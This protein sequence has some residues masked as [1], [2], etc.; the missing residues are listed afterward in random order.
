MFFIEY[1]ETSWYFLLQI[2]VSLDMF[3][4]LQF[5]KYKTHAERFIYEHLL[6]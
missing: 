6:G 5:I 4:F 2:L 1:I 3:E